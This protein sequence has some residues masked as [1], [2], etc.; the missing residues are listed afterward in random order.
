MPSTSA[1]RVRHQ[2]AS[3]AIPS[4]LPSL[5]YMPEVVRQGTGKRRPWMMS[6]MAASTL[7]ADF[8]ITSYPCCFL[9][10]LRHLPFPFWLPVSDAES[11]FDRLFATS[12]LSPSS[13]CRPVATKHT[14]LHIQLSMSD[15]LAGLAGSST[16]PGYRSISLRVPR[17]G[18]QQGLETSLAIR[19]DWAVRQTGCPVSEAR[20][21]GVGRGLALQ[22]A[23]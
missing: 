12:W 15:A 4:F 20:C 21:G 13:F 16:P 7:M 6:T 2:P 23:G 5:A 11:H 18:L 3:L 10:H 17:R 22:D 9:F 8:Y 19:L 1:V 14:D